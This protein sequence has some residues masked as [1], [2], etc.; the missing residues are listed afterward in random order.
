MT[1]PQLSTLILG[2]T[3]PDEFRPAVE[4]INR[5]VSP[6]S[7][8][9][10][11]DFKSMRPVIGDAWIPDLV[12]ALQAWP[13]QYSADDVAELISSC[14]LARIVCCCG[15]WCDSDGRTRTIWPLGVRVPAAAFANRFEHELA[16]LAGA[17]DA[18]L[19]L[20][21]TASRTEIFEFDF[22]R[23]AAP[24]HVARDFS[25]LSPDRRFRDMVKSALQS[26]GLSPVDMSG[27]SRPG[28]I[29]FDAD[30][31]DSDRAA[32]LTSLRRHH[33]QSRLIACIGF[34]RPH[35]E[36]ELRDAGANAIWFKI[37]PLA[38]LIEQTNAHSQLTTD[39]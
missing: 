13:D 1:S 33:P 9:S 26:S 3:A 20:P 17:P 28:T 15:P 7:R 25:T 5:H 2:D 39:H 21:L 11:A 19:P 4:L 24:R 16:V 18:G 22:A 30:P 12:I 14:P 29:I 27:A 34:S 31:W 8:R 10:A 37:A 35:L 6:G 32:A 36:T 23:A 38:D